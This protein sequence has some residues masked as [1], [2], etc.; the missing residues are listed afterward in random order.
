MD[1]VLQFML[2]DSHQKSKVF[3]AEFR[4]EKKIERGHEDVSFLSIIR[5]PCLQAYQMLVVQARQT[6]ESMYD[7]K[8]GLADFRAN[9]L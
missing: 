5:F 4:L 8:L 2:G 7:V 9:Q 6:F 3:K 1:E